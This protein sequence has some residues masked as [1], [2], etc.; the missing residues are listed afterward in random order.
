MTAAASLLGLTLDRGWEIAERVERP[1]NGTGG[2][3]SHSYIA[4]KDQEIAFVK[5]FDFS[6]AF[7]AGV[8]TVRILA[9]LTAGYEHEREVLEHCRGR[10]LSHVAVAIGHGYV[11]VPGFGSMAG[12]VYY[13]LF[14]KAE[15]DIRCQMDASDA[16]DSVWCI[17]ALRQVCL[18]LWQVHRELI[19]HQDVKPSNVLCY[20]HDEISP[21]YSARGEDVVANVA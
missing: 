2:T 1:Q 16:F 15:G 4:R 6:S 3:F 20:P 13:L 11:D 14:E 5:A 12:R 19:A 17:R 8:D 9:Q 7:A 21:L 18:G 10:R